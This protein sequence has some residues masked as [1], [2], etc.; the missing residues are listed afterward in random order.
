MLQM[1]A[2]SDT[3]NINK[4]IAIIYIYIYQHNT[5]EPGALPGAVAGLPVSHAPGR[6]PAGLPV[7]RA[8]GGLLAGV[9]AGDPVIDLLRN[10]KGIAKELLRNY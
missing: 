5:C 9:P 10:Y 7:N 1:I 8:P 3:A 6:L 2:I 4:I